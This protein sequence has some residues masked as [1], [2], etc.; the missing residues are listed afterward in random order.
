MGMLTNYKAIKARW[1]DIDWENISRD[2]VEAGTPIGADGMIHNDS[3]AIGILLKSCDR[4]WTPRGELMLEGCIDDAERLKVSNIKLTK[5][6]IHALHI[7][8][9]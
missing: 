8:F 3:I 9:V 1:I 5:S 7:K 6:C 4:Q 2:F